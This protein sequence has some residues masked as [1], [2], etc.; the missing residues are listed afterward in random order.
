MDEIGQTEAAGNDLAKR[1]VPCLIAYLNPF[2]MVE[3]ET[4]APWNAT[5]ADINGQSWDYSALHEMA[6]GLE[7]GLNSPYHLVV[8]R[9]GALAL[10]PIDQLRSDQSAVAF[11]NRCLAALLIGGV[12]CEAVTPDGLDLGSIID[13]KYVRSHRYGLAASNRFH[14]QI[15]YGK[16]SAIEAIT[17]FRPRTIAFATLQNAMKSGLE[18]LNL[19]PTLQGEYLLKGGTGLAR[20]DWGAAL[21]NLW[22]VTEQLVSGLWAREVVEPTLK[23]NPSTARRN[24]LNDTRT[25]T[26]SARLELLYQKG[27]IPAETF[28][29]LGKAR[30]ARNSLSHEG[31][32][33]SERDAYASYEGVRG[34]LSIALDGMRPA[35][36]DVDLADHSLSDPFAPPKRLEMQPEFWMEIPKLPGELELE[37]AEAKSRILK[38]RSRHEEKPSPG[39]SPG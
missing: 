18:V 13:W 21:A 2:R 12:Y 28:G 35:L 36:F 31:K 20:R 15:R 17:L 4:L 29:A 5:I 22:I 26:V 14:E 30:K 34:L 10:P 39:S 23:D 16:A 24:Q 32:H 8:T 9:D 6:G 25:W 27:V 3:A 33:P 11:F 1:R 7:V 37:R 19:L 38:R